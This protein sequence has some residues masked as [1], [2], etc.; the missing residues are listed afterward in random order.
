M[1]LASA[2]HALWNAGRDNTDLKFIHETNDELTK[3][4]IQLVEATALVT[5]LGLNL[6]SINALEEM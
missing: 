1:E 4:R 2:F 6:L 5:K 3:A